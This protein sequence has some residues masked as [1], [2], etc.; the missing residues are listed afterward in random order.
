MLTSEMVDDFYHYLIGI[1]LDK[2]HVYFNLSKRLIV[3]YKAYLYA[4]VDP[5]VKFTDEQAKW[6]I[7]GICLLKENTIFPDNIQIDYIL[8]DLKSGGKQFVALFENQA[9][10]L[11]F[12]E[13]INTAYTESLSLNSQP[14]T[15]IR[16]QTSKSISEIKT[17]VNVCTLRKVGSGK[18]THEV[19]TNLNENVQNDVTVNENLSFTVIAQSALM[20]LR[21]K[22]YRLAYQFARELINNLDNCPLPR[23]DIIRHYYFIGKMCLEQ[24]YAAESKQ[25]FRT[26]K[27]FAM[28]SKTVGEDLLRLAL[29]SSDSL[30]ENYVQMINKN[31]FNILF[32]DW[33]LFLPQIA[34]DP[35]ISL[36]TILPMLIE[37]HNIP[38]AHHH[39][40]LFESVEYQILLLIPKAESKDIVGTIEFFHVMLEALHSK[41]RYLSLDNI[42]LDCI[43][44]RFINFNLQTVE[45]ACENSQLIIANRLLSKIIKEVKRIDLNKSYLLGSDSLITF[46]QNYV[47]I[48]CKVE[49]LQSRIEEKAVN[50]TANTSSSSLT[51]HHANQFFTQRKRHCSAETEAKLSDNKRQRLGFMTP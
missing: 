22:S 17:I 14:F 39:I 12:C 32:C 10:A 6:V 48:L 45:L 7:S 33:K 23:N 29:H 27:D 8:D 34:H 47:A 9:D 19:N 13:D 16:L 2:N 42:F 50:N 21:N 43:R 25:D 40:D 5:E 4:A 28:C 1:T 41:S 31:R 35:L 44:I 30:A 46:F 38:G 26:A 51:F 49:A 18:T 24:T 3:S 37:L 15:P 36:Q 20:F 11:A